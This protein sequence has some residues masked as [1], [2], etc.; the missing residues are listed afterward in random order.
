MPDVIE[1]NKMIHI[2]QILSSKFGNEI[3]KSYCKSD[4]AK[5]YV[6]NQKR[7]RINQNLMSLICI[8]FIENYEINQ[9]L[10][11]TFITNQEK[12]QNR[13]SFE[14]KLCQ[15]IIGYFGLFIRSFYATIRY[16]CKTKKS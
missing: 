3:I 15:K 12:G 2:N 11:I 10:G 1:F 4:F 14:L 9:I 8:Y 6:T 5:S 16:G 7:V 13:S